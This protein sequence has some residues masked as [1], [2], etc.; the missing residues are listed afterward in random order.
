M[1]FLIDADLPRSTK[2]VVEA[3]GHDATDVRDI[4]LGGADDAVIA[5]ASSDGGGPFACRGCTADK[6]ALPFVIS[7]PSARG[8]VPILLIVVTRRASTRRSS[9]RAHHRQ[10][11]KVL[12]A[13]SWH[14]DRPAAG[15]AGRAYRKT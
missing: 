6:T 9:A 10:T 13:A 8:R 7:R 14:S 12:A 1:R 15:R 2:L 11:V 3:A 5:A 4:G